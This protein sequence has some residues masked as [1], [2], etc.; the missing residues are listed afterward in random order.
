MKPAPDSGRSGSQRPLTTSHS[1]C[2]RVVPD[3]SAFCRGLDVG[4]LTSPL[5]GGCRMLVWAT[6]GAVVR[7]RAYRPTT[8]AVA[9]P[10]KTSWPA[11]RTRAAPYPS[12]SRSETSVSS[13][14]IPSSIIGAPR[15]RTR[16]YVP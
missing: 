3:I 1:V 4:A 12:I 6:D 8:I 5:M 14:V 16:A 9:T 11:A 7:P 10:R 13:F 15:A 2:G